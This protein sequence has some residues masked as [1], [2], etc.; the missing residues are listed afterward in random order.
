MPAAVVGLFGKIVE[1][2]RAPRKG[3]K[4][5]PVDLG[6]TAQPLAVGEDIFGESV[7]V[8]KTE[9]LEP[10]KQISSRSLVEN[11]RDDVRQAHQ[12][13]QAQRKE[14]AL[15]SFD[16]PQENPACDSD[17]LA[18]A[19]L[20]MGM[21]AG[22]DDQQ[23]SDARGR[24][25]SSDDLICLETA[26]QPGAS[27]PLRQTAPSRKPTPQTP[28]D[29]LSQPPGADWTQEQSQSLLDSPVPPLACADI[30]P[31]RTP[32]LEPTRLVP[33]EKAAEPPTRDMSSKK[34][35]ILKLAENRAEDVAS[36]LELA[37][38]HVSVELK[39]GC[40]YLKDLSHSQ[41]DVG[42]GPY[43][44]TAEMLESLNGDDIPPS[45]IGFS[46][47][48]TTC[49]P[50]I[51]D[52]VKM[53]PSGEPPWVHFETQV[54]YEFSLSSEEQAP[55]VVEVDAETFNACCRGVEKELGDVYLHCVRRPWDMRIGVTQQTAL[56]HSPLHVAIADALVASMN[57]R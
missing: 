42:S 16:E 55:F 53:R 54:W 23:K 14:E 47:A 36:I 34:S 32:A 48:L 6:Q 40:F 7:P 52:L 12:E 56:S 24:F 10:T 44:G 46:T 38:G 25:D 37:P 50:D 45:C 26:P 1:A 35:H 9:P 19:H 21:T 43:W 17:L 20:D 2:S 39:F 8:L 13:E 57:V 18:A 29:R 49:G 22:A 28:T 30:Q 27:L 41:I 31:A 33:P 15:I 5:V 51:E 11:W 3:T 4:P